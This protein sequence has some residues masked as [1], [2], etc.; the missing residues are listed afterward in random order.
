MK[1]RIS[2]S[3]LIFPILFFSVASCSTPKKVSLISNKDRSGQE[4]EEAAKAEGR[5]GWSFEKA[6]IVNSISEE[7]IW[8]RTKFPGSGVNSQALIKNNGKPYDLILFVTA[9]GEALKAHF[10]ISKFYGKGF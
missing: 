3:I 4:I 7:Y 1:S 5:D 6:I 9:D 8:I 2:F 10:D